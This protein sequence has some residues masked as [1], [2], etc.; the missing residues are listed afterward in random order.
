VSARLAAADAAQLRQNRL[1]TAQVEAANA[2]QHVAA[3]GGDGA[4]RGEGGGGDIAVA[5]ERSLDDATQGEEA[6]MTDLGSLP[7]EH[8]AIPEARSSRSA[9]GW[10]VGMPDAEATA[11]AGNQNTASSS[12]TAELEATAASRKGVH[13]GGGVLGNDAVTLFGK[14]STYAKS[15]TS[16][17]VDAVDERE[18]IDAIARDDT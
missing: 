11:A 8:P 14:H 2:L 10:Q 9:G 7:K 17:G 5:F 1:R 18:A 13:A 12:G 3:T 6:A 4:S 16:G 15:S